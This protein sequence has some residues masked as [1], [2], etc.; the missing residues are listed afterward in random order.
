[1]KPL[2]DKVYYRINELAQAFDVKPS[3]LRYWEKEFSFLIKP[4]K[5]NKGERLFTKKDVD[6]F[7]SIF[8]L[9]KENGYT[10]D[11][12]KKK[13]RTERQ[14]VN[15]NLSVIERLEKIKKELKKIRE[16]L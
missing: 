6:N 12:A 14:K 4:K 1:M 7:K 3:L 8:Y 2:P 5:N 15:K 13:L 9:V 10:L 11:G 16:N